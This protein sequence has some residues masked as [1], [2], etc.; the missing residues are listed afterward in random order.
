[1]LYQNVAKATFLRRP[2]RFI[3]EVQLNDRIE[4]VHVPNTG[5]CAELFIPGVPVILSASSNPVRKTHFSL[6]AVEKK[7][8]WI[9]IDSQVP[10]AVV[11]DAVREGKIPEFAGATAVKREVCF[12]KSRF[13]IYLETPQGRGFIEVKGVT[14]EINGAAFFP[15]AP[16]LRGTKHVEEM[17]Q[18]VK[19][20]YLGCI[21]FLVQMKDVDY[22][23]PHQAMDP[24]FTQALKKAAHSGVKILAFDSLV[25]EN[26]ILLG[27]RVT[28]V[29]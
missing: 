10:N 20:G 23:A 3:A 8:R 5:R 29:I 15:D 6:I 1:M 25:N 28:V 19:G 2:N 9:N 21:F 24:E 27:E 13:D 16:T 11:A 17:I 18:A 26:S 4:K 12:Q 7:G 22:F 14:L